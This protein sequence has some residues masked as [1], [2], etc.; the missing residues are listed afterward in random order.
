M[1]SLNQSLRKNPLFTS[2]SEEQIEYCIQVCSPQ[3]VD[4]S[5]G[6][7]VVHRNEHFHKIGLVLTGSVAVHQNSASGDA[8]IVGWMVENQVFAEVLAFEPSVR[9]PT[10]ISAYQP[11][12]VCYFLPEMIQKMEDQE[13]KSIL[14][15]N[16]VSS[17]SRKAVNL[18]KK[19]EL[20]SIR[21]ITG[22]ICWF[23]IDEFHRTQ[24]TA[25][26][27]VFNRDQMAAYLQVSRPSL[28][29][30]LAKLQQS[31]IIRYEKNHFQILDLSQCQRLMNE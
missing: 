16:L 7:I 4:Y 10:D 6:D 29:R 22:K 11:T 23:L 3:V 15:F 28:S 2:L 5:K 8:S 31:G 27:L 17:M 26:T 20:L 25:F 21:S 13:I 18:H 12:S 1:P 14:L 19:I 30:E 24:K 9:Y